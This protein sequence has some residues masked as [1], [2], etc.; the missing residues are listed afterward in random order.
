MSWLIFAL[1]EQFWKIQIFGPLFAQNWV[2]FLQFLGPL[3]IGEQWLT[4]GITS[5]TSC[6][7]K[8][9]NGQTLR[10]LFGVKFGTTF[11]RNFGKF[12]FYLWNGHFCQKCL[13]SS[14]CC[15]LT[16]LSK[17]EIQQAIW[18]GPWSSRKRVQTRWS[19]LWGRASPDSL[20]SWSMLKSHVPRFL[21]NFF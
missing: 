1:C 9:I 7:A 21:M 20:G 11:E 10:S 2:P 19:T 12:Y 8:Y 18:A 4:D 16:F 13:F 14:V 3:E 17:L 6:D 5:R 15:S